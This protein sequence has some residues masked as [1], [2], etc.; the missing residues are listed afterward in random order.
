MH[1]PP[2]TTLRLKAWK[3]YFWFTTVLG[4]GTLLLDDFMNGLVQL[5][6]AVGLYGYIW[7]VPIANHA[8]WQLYLLGLAVFFCFDLLKF[9]DP[10]VGF[11]IAQNELLAI[12]MFALVVVLNGPLFYALIHYSSKQHQAW[13][14]HA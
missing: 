2:T 3:W 11:V 9:A 4:L 12:A 8:V 7:S 14:Q 6:G 13:K 10:A 1:S 5:F